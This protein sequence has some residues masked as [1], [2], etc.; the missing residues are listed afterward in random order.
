[1]QSAQNK[2]HIYSNMHIGGWSG[3]GARASDGIPSMLH[4]YC[5]SRHRATRDFDSHSQYCTHRS[6]RAPLLP[7]AVHSCSLQSTHV[8]VSMHTTGLAGRG[9]SNETACN[10]DSLC[11]ESTQ[12]YCAARPPTHCGGARQNLEAYFPSPITRRAAASRPVCVPLP[13]PPFQHAY[14]AGGG[15]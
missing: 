6:R 3:W 5:V 15:V 11:I 2:L 4:C 1:M 8:A 14:G 7:L 12:D 13:A 9:G 10:N